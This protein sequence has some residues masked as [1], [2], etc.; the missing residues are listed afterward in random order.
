VRELLAALPPRPPVTTLVVQ[1]IAAGFEAGMADWLAADL[2]LDVGLAGEG[3]SPP[4]GAVR[5]APPGAHLRLTAGGVLGLD[6]ETPPRRGHRPAVDELFLSCARCCPDRVAA[7]LLTGM[8]SDGV[9]GMA[10]LAAGGALTL[11]QDEASSVVY[12]MPRAAWAR[13]VASRALPPA[14]IAREVA[15]CWGG[16]AG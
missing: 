13:G 10:E 7:V 15:R 12:G 14:E 5:L 2:G 6:R 9:E 8:G 16:G 4:P 11:V 3:E 1:H